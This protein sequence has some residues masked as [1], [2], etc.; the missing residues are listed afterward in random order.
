M[1]DVTPETEPTELERTRLNAFIR[2]AINQSKISPESLERLTQLE[3]PLLPNQ[4]LI[5]ADIQ[6]ALPSLDLPDNLPLCPPVRSIA[7]FAVGQRVK[8][9]HDM[10]SQFHDHTIDGLV[11]NYYKITPQGESAHLMYHL[12][13]PFYVGLLDEDSFQFYTSDHPRQ[14]YDGKLQVSHIYIATEIAVI[15]SRLDVVDAPDEH[16]IRNIRR[17][18]GSTADHYIIRKKHTLPIKR[19][20]VV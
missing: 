6:A 17:S 4:P 11:E 3:S 14:E 19:Q 10:G 5:D 15:L 13:A 9:F 18:F 20:P 2:F 1:V 16:T 8:V 12:I 7:D